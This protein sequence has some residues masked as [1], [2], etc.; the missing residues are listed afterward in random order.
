MRAYA[1]SDPAGRDLRPW[2][3]L[4]D[5]HGHD[6]ILTLLDTLGTEDS[7]DI[8][9]STAHRAKGREWSSVRI[10][11]GFLAE[12]EPDENGRPG[13]INPTDARLAYVAITRAR[14]HLDPSTLTWI[15]HHPAPHPARTVPTPGTANPETATA[16]SPSADDHQPAGV[17]D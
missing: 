2:A 5:D 17:A 13:T 1:T 4:V 15:H 14:H 16:S 8:T 11:D 7:A 9:V 12:P 3:Q 10:S 6:T